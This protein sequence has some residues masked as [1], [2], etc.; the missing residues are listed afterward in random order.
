MFNYLLLIYEQCL[1][2]GL[3]FFLILLRR[4]FKVR[5]LKM[6]FWF[7]PFSLYYSLCG[8]DL[9]MFLPSIPSCSLAQPLFFGVCL[10]RFAEVCGRILVCRWGRERCSPCMARLSAFQLL[11]IPL[12]L[13]CDRNSILF[14]QFVYK[15]HYYFCTTW[16]SGFTVFDGYLGWP[17]ISHSILKIIPD[18]CSGSSQ[19]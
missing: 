5:S 6:M 17:E 4:L 18:F 3:R 8:S 9:L 10:K 1:Q 12:W 13:Q 11:G 7:R 16:Q 2:F 19:W 15:F 14:I